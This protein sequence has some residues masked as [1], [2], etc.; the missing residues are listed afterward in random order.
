M[1]H[2]RIQASPQ[3]SGEVIQRIKCAV[4]AVMETYKESMNAH[5][6]ANPKA[7][8]Q[9]FVLEDPDRLSCMSVARI[10]RDPDLTPEKAHTIWVEDRKSLG[11]S[12]KP[13]YSKDRR[14]HPFLVG[15]SSLPKKYRIRDRLYFSLVREML[16]LVADTT[17]G[18]VSGQLA[19]THGKVLRVGKQLPIDSSYPSPHS[20]ATRTVMSRR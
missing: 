2:T 20:N 10:A 9:K 12:Y 13:V 7:S 3:Y 6:V 8:P 17:S 16:S 18:S 11:W 14:T 19:T 4:E 1:S 5:D 15:Y